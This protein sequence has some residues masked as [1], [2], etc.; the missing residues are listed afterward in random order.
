M[1]DAMLSAP[2]PSRGPLKP[3]SPLAGRLGPEAALAAPDGTAPGVTLAEVP[4]GALVQLNGWDD[5]YDRLAAAAG[6]ALGVTPPA[7]TRMAVAVRGVSTDAVAPSP[8]LTLFRIAPTRLLVLQDAAAGHDTGAESAGSA[9]RL[10]DR[11]APAVRVEDGTLVD[12]SEA[13][14]RLRLSGPAG[15]AV[16]AKGLPIDLRP[17]VFGIGAFAQSVFHHVDV[18][19]HRVGDADAAAAAAAGET[20]APS[21]DPDGVPVF[22]ILVARGFAVA[23]VDALL[24]AAAEHGVALG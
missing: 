11:L 2:V 16:F 3:V 23:L 15:R 7:D 24:E 9:A 22:E 17:E 4:V 1:P 6:R 13:R 19:V 8:G 14:V 18:L 12:L 21:G 5:S 10:A 20:V